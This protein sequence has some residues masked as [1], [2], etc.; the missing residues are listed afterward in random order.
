[1]K[2][3]RVIAVVL[4]F[5]ILSWT[6]PANA[7]GFN[8]QYCLPMV[9]CPRF[10]QLL[11]GQQAGTVLQPTNSAPPVALGAKINPLRSQPR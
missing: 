9:D 7:G 4:A 5:P 2:S 10:L 1:M 11:A 6:F 8:S 3:F